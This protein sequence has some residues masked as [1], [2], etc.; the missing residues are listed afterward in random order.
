LF[1]NSSAGERRKRVR[2]KKMVGTGKVKG[3]EQNGKCREV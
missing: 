1:K 2:K 3:R